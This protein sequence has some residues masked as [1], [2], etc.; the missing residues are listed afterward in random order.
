MHEPTRLATDATSTAA[1]TLYSP[2]W[3]LKPANSIVG[4]DG[5]GMHALS[6]VIS[7]K[8][9]GSPMASTTS[10]AQLAT[11]SVM[12]ATTSMILRSRSVAAP[13][14]RPYASP[15]PV[16]GLAVASPLARADGDRRSAGRRRVLP[17]LPPAV[18]RGRSP[19]LR[20]AVLRDAAL[21]RAGVPGGV[22]ALRALRQA[23]ALRHSARPR[24]RAAGRAGR[25]RR[26]DGGDRR[27][28]SGHGHVAH[29]IRR[30]QP[31]VRARRD[32]LP[33]GARLRRRRAVD[34]PD[35]LRAPAARL[36]AGQGRPARPDR[37]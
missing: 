9:P 10:I 6:G 7:R 33:A 18:R 20:A 11:V 23:L 31:P 32:V 15:V 13:R 30:R 34:R 8:I 2:L 24:G 36:Q 12:E 26:A 37:G 28:P 1:R 27:D 29:R 3:T 17:R 16:G 22:P 4:S 14:M 35:A 21:G 25:H 5:I 19:A